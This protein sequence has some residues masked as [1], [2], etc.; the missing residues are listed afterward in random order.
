MANSLGLLTGGDGKQ[1]SAGDAMNQVVEVAE[2]AS[3]LIDII[4][5]QANKSK[6]AAR[7]DDNEFII[8]KNFLD[9]SVALLK[10]ATLGQYN[11]VIAT[12]IEG[13]EFK[14]LQGRLLP[15]D[16]L[17]LEIAPGKMVKFLVYLFDTG[18]YLRRGKWEGNYWAWTGESKKFSQFGDPAMHVHFDNAQTKLNPDDI[19]K[20]NEESGATKKAAD[21]AAAASKISEEI[22]KADNEETLALEAATKLDA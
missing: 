19:K 21:D 18:K 22:A 5:E 8:R 12:D 9:N 15:M 20:K 11:I 3:K 10:D 1:A 13:D 4:R 2:G 17:D 14:D 16:T 7:Q 6:E